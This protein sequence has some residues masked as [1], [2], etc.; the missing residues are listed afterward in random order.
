MRPSKELPTPDSAQFPI[1]SFNKILKGLPCARH[2]P[3]GF[4]KR[5]RHSAY[6]EPDGEH[7]GG[8]PNLQ[9]REEVG[10]SPWLFSSQMLSNLTSKPQQFR[11]N[12]SE[13]RS[14]IS[15]GS[16]SEIHS[17]F[18]PDD[19][20]ERKCRGLWGQPGPVPMA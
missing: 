16:P 18:S 3:R 11:S 20:E 8:A 10:M 14:R 15:P 5:L 7:G 4:Q 12:Y 17:T 6:E 2:C 13:N 1:S 9:L 19:S